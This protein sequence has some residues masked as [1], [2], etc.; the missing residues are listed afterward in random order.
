MHRQVVGNPVTSK[1]SQ[2]GK[3][4]HLKVQ[5]LLKCWIK[6]EMSKSKETVGKLAYFAP[7]D[8]SHSNFGLFCESETSL[9]G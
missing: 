5:A 3:G 8:Q 1:K 4:L 2:C 7:K 6:A 9:P